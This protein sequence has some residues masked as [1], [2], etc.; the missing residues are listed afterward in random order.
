MTF[1][2]VE[3]KS[4]AIILGIF[5]FQNRQLYSP[6]WSTLPLETFVCSTSILTRF[7][8]IVLDTFWLS[9]DCL[10]YLGDSVRLLCIPRRFGLLIIM[11]GQDQKAQSRN[12][13][14]F[15]QAFFAETEYSELIS[16]RNL[17]EILNR[18]IKKMNNLVE[19]HES[20]SCR[21]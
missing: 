20:S 19:Q 10:G 7:R 11:F 21:S 9:L 12:M 3:E 17:K 6:S 1:Q 2:V 16:F 4:I 15:G 5:K 14:T 18:T 8:Q 13:I